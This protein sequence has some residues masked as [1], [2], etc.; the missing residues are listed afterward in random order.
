M[1]E[2]LV[3]KLLMTLKG[4]H[5]FSRC[6]VRCGGGVNKCTPFFVTIK[7]NLVTN[8]TKSKKST[9]LKQNKPINT[10]NI[11]RLDQRF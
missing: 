8:C 5:H 1:R 3:Q 9:L 2:G 7:Y 4:G 11:H 10:V 6:G